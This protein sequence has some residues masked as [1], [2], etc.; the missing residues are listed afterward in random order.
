MPVEFV[1]Q[2]AGEDSSRCLLDATRVM[3]KP[4][5]LSVERFGGDGVGNTAKPKPTAPPHANCCVPQVPQCRTA[6]SPWESRL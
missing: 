1:V 2:S 6:P 3:D 5:G 4:S